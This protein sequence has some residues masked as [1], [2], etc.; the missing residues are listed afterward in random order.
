MKMDM[1]CRVCGSRDIEVFLDLGDQPHCNRLV[2]EALLAKTKTDPAYPL[3]AGFCHDCTLVQIDHTIP[4]EQMFSDYPYVSGTTRT[5]VE[6]FRQTAARLVETYGLKSGDRVVD[7]GS[8]DGSWLAQYQ[9]FGLTAL[10]VEAAANVADI[11][12]GRGI[13]TL[14]RFFNAET[15][16]HILSDHGPARLVTAAGVFFH[17]EE[18]HSVVEGIHR[19]IGDDGVFV[20]QAIYL[21]GMVENLAFDQIYHEHL[22]YYTLRSLEALFERHGLAVFDVG[23]VPIHG[24]SIEVHVARTGKRAASPRVAAFRETEARKGFG[25]FATYRR[26]GERVWELRDQ[27]L[28]LLR[29]LRSQGLTIHAFGAPAKGAT[30]LNSFG[31]GPDLVSKAVEKNPMKVGMAIPGCRIPI[32]GEDEPAPNA[33]LMLAWNFL[34]EFLAREKPYLEAGGRFIVPVPEL[35]VIGGGA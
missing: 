15:A 3:R 21:G 8:N 10:G 25:E 20:V 30:L 5:L 34:D 23:L 18:L 32:V 1:S 14:N 2:P 13:Q 31:I 35:K 16:D 24:G 11:A 22:C 17:L 12:N 27:L 19:L 6:H 28:G 33:F 7:I 26:F 29:D 9:P 4:K